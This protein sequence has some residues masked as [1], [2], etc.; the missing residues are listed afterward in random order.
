MKNTTIN[1]VLAVLGIVIGGIYILNPTAGLLELIP[2]VVPVVGN[3]DEAAA[4]ALILWGI[5]AI[6]Q[7]GTLPALPLKK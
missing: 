5:Q 7:P 4:T 1:K 2:D 6:R 3:L